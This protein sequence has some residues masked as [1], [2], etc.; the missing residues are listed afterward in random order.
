MP[1]YDR[2]YIAPTWPRQRVRP[3]DIAPWAADLKAGNATIGRTL[4]VVYGTATVTGSYAW[5]DDVQSAPGA[6]FEG[7]GYTFADCKVARVQ[8][9]ICEGPIYGIALI[10]RGDKVCFADPSYNPFSAPDWKLMSEPTFSGLKL[11]GT[12]SFPH[13]PSYTVG[14]RPEST[15]SP[16]A[17]DPYRTGPKSRVPF[18]GTAVFRCE[19][20]ILPDGKLPDLAFTVRGRLAT[21]DTGLAFGG[22]TIFGALPG[23]IIRDLLSDPIFGVGMDVACVDTYTGPEGDP[24]GST[25]SVGSPAA[26]SFDTYCLARSWFL[27]FALDKQEDALDVVGRILTATNSTAVWTPGAAG[28]L[29]KLRILPLGDSAV[30]AYEPPSTPAVVNEDDFGRAGGGDPVVVER[31]ADDDIRQV[32]PVKFYALG[33][34]GTGSELTA[35]ESGV[36]ANP[37][38]PPAAR[39]D[40]T[41]LLGV[42]NVQHAQ[43]ISLSLAQR[44]T[45]LRNTY[46]LRLSWRHVY[47]EPGDLI[48]VTHPK[49]GMVSTVLRVTGI[50]EES[51][52]TLS[53]EAVEWSGNV[54]TPI[55]HTIESGDGAAD[56][57]Q[58][59]TWASATIAAYTSDNVL[60]PPE[61]GVIIREAGSLKSDLDSGGLVSQAST[62][63]IDSSAYDTAIDALLSALAG[64]GLDLTAGS[65]SI[66]NWAMTDTSV[67]GATLRGLFDT[68]YLERT[69][70]QQRLARAIQDATSLV[71][72]GNLVFNS[73]FNMGPGAFGSGW[74]T[75]TADAWVEYQNYSDPGD[76][77]L[78]AGSGGVDGGAYVRLNFT[79]C[80]PS[81]GFRTGGALASTRYAG[82]GIR[83][84]WKAGKTYVVSFWARAF[85]PLNDG[86][87]YPEL[88][89]NTAPTTVALLCPPLLQ[90]WQRYAW[91]ITWGESVEGDGRLY[92]SSGS[93]TGSST[94]SSFDVDHVQVEEG[95]VLTAYR[96]LTQAGADDVLARSG[97]AL[98]LNA[99]GTVVYRKTGLGVP[100]IGDDNSGTNPRLLINTI[101]VREVGSAWTENEIAF[102]LQ[103][104]AATDNLDGVTHLEVVPYYSSGGNAG[105]WSGGATIRLPISGRRYVSG[106]TTDSSNAAGT[107]YKFLGWAITL[108]A[109]SGYD[110]PMYLVARICSA[111]GY[112]TTYWFSP[113]SAAGEG[114]TSGTGRWTCVGTT[115][116]LTGGSSGAASGGGGSDPYCPTPDTLVLL[117]GGATMPAGLLNVGDLVWTRSD[118]E[119]SPSSPWAAY[120]VTAV[121]REENSISQV[122]FRDGGAETFAGN[123][124]VWTPQ[125][126]RGIRDLMRGDRVEGA[127][128][129]SREVVDVLPFAARGDVIRITV[130]G[131]ATYVAGNLLSHNMKP[132]G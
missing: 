125:G 109:L 17:S 26:S 104:L 121:S 79:T 52:A 116:P 74:S 12:P 66:S 60:S 4:P 7:T 124:R 22:V 118:P 84:G 2:E 119:L 36:L 130:D 23:D 96:S 120:P 103:P 78:W 18:G 89:W 5:F 3:T 107:H 98:T 108:G 131:P 45:S 46:R 10:N 55:D 51:D 87:R 65:T 43:A 69:R 16:V 86:S 113:P 47:L 76:E 62:L 112:S 94:Q 106:T 50:Q 88:A 13:T 56:Q 64:Y 57:L 59:T 11:L 111:D 71:G 102:K 42:T 61:K 44:S 40:T 99:D 95:A 83:N 81:K 75:G 114:T 101:N 117:A 48:S 25:Y 30:G 128:G 105:Y 28:A 63:G 93:F 31:S 122:K 90:S 35:T 123:H 97:T 21:R 32:W 132:G 110:N 77:W 73:S 8:V 9:A 126:W 67:N 53:V 24:T 49:L 68:C 80:R 27:S 41:E 38:G 19:K 82:G 58:P 70:V 91:R 54:G 39:A 14:N 100:K 6:V 33:A 15:W 29:G 85:G 129:E 1:A 34:G 72:G 92:I 127:N 20:M 37:A 115:S